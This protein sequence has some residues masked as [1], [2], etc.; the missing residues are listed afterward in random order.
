MAGEAAKA[1]VDR[2]QLGRDIRQLGLEVIRHH[3]AS[4]VALHQGEHAQAVRLGRAV[5]KGRNGHVHRVRPGVHGRHIGGGTDTGR[6]V[7]VDPH[8]Q[9][10]GLLES[11]H[12]ISRLLRRDQ[13]CHVLDDDTVRAH[14]G[15]LLA[16]LGE[17]LQVVDG[18]SG[19]ADSTVCRSTGCLG[20][21]NGGT[22]VL[23]VVQAVEDTED[24]HAVLHAHLHESLHHVI[25]VVRVAHQILTAQQHGVRR[26]GG[27]L[28]ERVK[29]IEGE[30]PEEAQT[31]INGRAAPGLQCGEAH[32]VEDG[33]QLE[34]LLGGH[35]SGCQRLVTVAKHCAIECCG[36]HIF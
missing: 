12:E 10:C 34:H 20:R 35:A 5:R 27:Q 1:L 25:G 31:G 7:R 21:L 18:G 28:L 13:A 11:G 17:V 23:R 26:L 29:S 9:P 24:V 16:Q 32:G 4:L 19:V 14:I 33:S 30:L 8:R 22:H 3:G 15:D 36:F 2:L 6:V